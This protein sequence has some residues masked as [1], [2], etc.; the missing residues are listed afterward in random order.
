[1]I[2]LLVG[3][4][5]GSQCGQSSSPSPRCLRA[6]QEQINDRI[7]REYEQSSERAKA[8]LSTGSRKKAPR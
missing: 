3:Y 6:R 7:R 5:I 8:L 4:V 2:E 1:M